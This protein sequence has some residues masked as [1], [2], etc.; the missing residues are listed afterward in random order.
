M[1]G[2]SALALGLSALALGLFEVFGP[3]KVLKRC[4]SGAD[5]RVNRSNIRPWLYSFIRAPAAESFT[6][7]IKLRGPEFLGASE[8]VYFCLDVTSCLR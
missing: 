2:L 4:L 3:H 5:H 8:P 1:L 6:L 7:K